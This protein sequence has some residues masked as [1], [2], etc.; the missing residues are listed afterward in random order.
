L[1]RHHRRYKIVP[2]SSK[3]IGKAEKQSS[4][5]DPCP[6]HQ[7]HA[8]AAQKGQGNSIRQQAT[9]DRP[10]RIQQEGRKN[11]QRVYLRSR[12][13]AADHVLSSHH[14]RAND[15]AGRIRLPLTA[16][17][18]TGRV[19]ETAVECYNT[20]RG[21]RE[22]DRWGGEAP[23]TS[24]D[25][26]RRRSGARGK[27]GREGRAGG[28]GRANESSAPCSL[29]AIFIAETGTEATRNGTSTLLCSA[30]VSELRAV[31]AGGVALGRPRCF[32]LSVSLVAHASHSLAFV[33]VWPPSSI[34]RG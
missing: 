17:T 32:L 30:A 8:F 24:V 10:K 23:P 3:Q 15:R 21:E 11:L 14:Q 19:R 4:S 31:R 1:I 6:P 27:R 28:W 5:P 12:A 7:S 22:A 16:C 20:P 2:W 33:F 18:R 29:A 26:R 34:S 25:R 13:R 9:A